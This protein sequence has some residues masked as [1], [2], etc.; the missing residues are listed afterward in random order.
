MFELPV[1]L[2]SWII[3]GATAVLILNTLVIFLL[4]LIRVGNHKVA[5]TNPDYAAL[6]KASVIVFSTD[7]EERLLTYLDS[8]TKQEYP[9]F[10]VIV[11][12]DTTADT[13]KTLADLCESRYRNVYLTFIPPGS[14]NLSRRKL[15][16]TLGIKAA[17]GEVVVTTASNVRIPSDRWLIE[18]LTPFCNKS[19]DISLGYSHI[20][21]TQIKGAGRWYR[22]FVS[23]LTDSNWIGTALGHWPYRGDG[24]NLAFRRQLFF[25]HKGYSK[26][27]HLHS[28]DD[29]LFINEISNEKNTAVVLSPQTILTSDWG[30]AAKRIWS[31]QK[32]QYDFTSRWL[33]RAPFILSGIVSA[34]QWF[35]PLCCIGAGYVGYPSIFPA[36]IGSLMI[37]IFFQSEI[38][39][40]R[41]AAAAMQ[42]TRLWW[43]LPLFWL[44]KPIGNAL[45][46]I[47]HH[48][49][50]RKNYTWQ[51]K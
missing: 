50:H 19:T 25:D 6:P 42:A 36:I 21:Y 34:M 11:V 32:E 14:H 49:E 51:R 7:D 38:I 8:V 41:R 43:A 28:G 29:D 17:K 13:K 15:A 33:P 47:R 9:D 26:S 16:L 46:H 23:L 4:P 2:S 45:F 44:F 39:I 40:Y 3:L 20:D 18:L 24:L 12:C 48:S 10:E 31:S 27:I 5:E 37:I 22:E 1:S 30:E 35:I